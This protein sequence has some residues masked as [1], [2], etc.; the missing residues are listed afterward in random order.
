ML[1]NLKLTRP[2]ASID[3]E[4]TGLL[5]QGA[6]VV[7][8]AIVRVNPNLSVDALVRRLNPGMPIPPQATAV[9]G[10]TDADVANC[11]RFAGVAWEV[12][13]ALLDCDLCG[14]NVLGF[15]LP[16]ID[17][18]IARLGAPGGWLARRY[19]LDA[20]L[21]FH[22]HYPPPRGVHGYGTLTAACRRYLGGALPGAH[23]ALSD[24]LAALWVLDTQVAYHG[25]PP[26]VEGLAAL[27]A[28]LKPPYRPAPE[29]PAAAVPAEQGGPP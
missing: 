25:L 3:V 10:I 5:E 29:L 21:I 16:V 7:E 12:D 19:A 15:D 17:G 20:M 6:R 27:V 24:A 28:G 1:R 4:T 9:H 13:N 18:E 11:P 22:A 2:L 8:I 23:G 26:T 14:F